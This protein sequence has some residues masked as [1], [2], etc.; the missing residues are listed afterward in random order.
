MIGNKLEIS[1]CWN[2]DQGID[3]PKQHKEALEEDALNRIFEM[4][5]EGY[6][7]GELSTSVR[8]GVEIVPEENPEDGLT[9]SGHWSLT[10]S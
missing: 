10:K 6:Y 2:C 7:S 4:I 3:I 1:Y 5:K 9:Y 8:Y